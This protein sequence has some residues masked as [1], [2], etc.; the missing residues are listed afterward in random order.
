MVL[1]YLTILAQS[2]H[3]LLGLGSWSTLNLVKT[4]D[5]IKVSNMPDAN[6]EEEEF[7]DGWDCIDV[8]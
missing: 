5:V 1:D 3:A 6:G 8:T 7:E 4:E 2:T